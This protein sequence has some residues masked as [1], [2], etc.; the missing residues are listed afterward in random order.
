MLGN[1]R[2]AQPRNSRSD[3]NGVLEPLERG[4]AGDLRLTITKTDLSD[5]LHALEGLI[6]LDCKL[7]E[8]VPL[9]LWPSCRICRQH[10]ELALRDDS[11]QRM[12]ELRPRWPGR[13][14]RKQYR[15][16]RRRYPK[17]D[18]QP[19]YCAQDHEQCGARREMPTFTE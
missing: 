6:A 16:H 11:C 7:N 5:D 12:Q 14:L 19:K 10:Q 18:G 8:G 13:D 15:V 17:R 4:D 2:V 3:A 9:G 1:M